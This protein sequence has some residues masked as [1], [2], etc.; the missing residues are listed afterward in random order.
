MHVGVAGV[1]IIVVGLLVV[2]I[3][4]L[5]LVA[6]QRRRPAGGGWYAGGT[7]QQREVAEEYYD[8]GA[9]PEFEG[10]GL[11]PTTDSMLRGDLAPQRQPDPEPHRS[12]PDPSDGG[13][14]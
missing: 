10:D 13:P 1:A 7:K 11:P 6:A 3:V 14:T 2:V 5:L 4:V 8:P 9:D 12:V